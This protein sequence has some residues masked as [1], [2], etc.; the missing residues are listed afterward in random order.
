M[1][2]NT[3]Y[4]IWR[5]TTTR[6]DTE[7]DLIKI[8]SHISTQDCSGCLVTVTDRTLESEQIQ[9]LLLN[10]TYLIFTQVIK[11][12]NI[13]Y[14]QSIVEKIAKEYFSPSILRPIV[15]KNQQNKCYLD[16]A[17]CKDQ[18]RL[19]DIVLPL[20][21]RGDIFI[22]T[23]ESYVNFSGVSRIISILEIF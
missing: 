15:R 11:Q 10:N 6:A 13:P 9:C 18:L 14:A 16:A 4:K 17:N 2:Y 21:I 5:R 20:I 7:F 12:E 8:L 23:D 1:E 22:F 3:A 19:C